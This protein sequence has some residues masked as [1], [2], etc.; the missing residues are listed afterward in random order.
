M[1][2]L[3]PH[4]KSYDEHLPD[5]S[6]PT[7]F[8]RRARRK[9]WQLRHANRMLLR[10]AAPKSPLGRVL[11][12]AVG[13]ALVLALAALASE[14]AHAQT[15]TVIH[16]FAGGTDGASPMAGLTF[17]GA[18]NLYGLANFGGNSGGNCGP[19]GCGLVYKL[20][21]R[22]SS[23][24]LTSLYNFSG[25]ND[26]ANPQ[27][28]NVVFGPDGALYGSTY[29]G[30][31]G[32]PGGGCGTVFKLQPPANV[33]RNVSCPWTETILHR[34]DGSDGAGPVGAVVFDSEGNL[35]GATNSGSFNNGG[36][37]YQLNAGGWHEQILFHPYGYPGSSV[38]IGNAENLYGTTFNGGLNKFGSIYQLTQSG[39][40]WMETDLY[41]FTNGAD[42]AY[43]VAGVI[44]D[45]AGNVYGTT[46]SGGAQNGGTVFKLT[47]V[48]GSW[49]YNLL[50]SFQGLNNGMFINGPVGN[51]VMDAAG[52]LYG[53]TLGDGAFGYGAVFKLSPWNGSWIYTSL[54]DFT[55]GS[56]GGNPFSNLIFDASGNLYGTASSG[57]SAG[58]G[59]AFE[60]TP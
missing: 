34:F 42:G 45:E 56:D 18:G 28:A 2:G 35:D 1:A 44:F 31:G 6:R 52:N 41:D 32:C 5:W 38:S 17:D 48:N 33:C 13:L 16:N 51:L 9:Y 57:G 29:Y 59:V 46:S 54:H 55:G 21:K 23:W 36:A 11:A 47:N 14:S 3:Q 15:Y 37:I 26:G 58:L 39:L 10:T 8:G 43:P 19:R 4:I 53:T 24:V 50:Y 30:G 7:H 49:N 27:S 20:I 22:N 12:A 25:G 60:I 40:G